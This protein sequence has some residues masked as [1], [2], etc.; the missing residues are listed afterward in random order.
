[1]ST[2]RRTALAILVACLFTAVP[3]IARAGSYTVYGCRTPTGT[4]APVNGWSYSLQVYPAYW[5]NSCPGETFM[6]MAASTP[7]G[8]GRYAE[9]T[10]VA[11]PGT[12]IH[13]YT[14]VRAVRLVSSGGY[15]YQ[16]L[17]NSRGYWSMVEGCNTYTS[18]PSF[19]D[20]KHATSSSNVLSRTAPSG[21][22]QVQLKI[23]CGMS[24]GCP[25]EP[26]GVSASVWMFQ[27]RMTL[28]DDLA[29]QFTGPPSG[30]L[31]SGGVLSGTVP[32]SIGAADQ[33][34]G[35]DFAEV[36]VDGRVLLR[37]VLDNSTGACQ[38][39]F[40]APAPCPLS[41]NGTLNFNT[42]QLPDGTHNLRLAV[43]DAAG[44]VATWGPVA[45][46]TVNN[47]CSPV[48]AAAGMR[49]RAAFAI[50]TR[51]RIRIHGH[52][53]VVKRVRFARK[54]TAN[55]GQH[56]VVLGGLTTT[57][58]TPVPGA[59][60]CIAAQNDLRG[61]RLTP[62]GAVTTNAGGGFLF[63]LAPGPSRTV[64]MIYRVPAGAIFAK[65]HIT[66]HAPVHIHVNRFHFHNGD[67]MSWTGH[68]PGPIP[69]GM[70]ALMQV[71]RGTY[72]QDFQKIAVDRHGRWRGRYRFAFTTGDQRYTF[73]LLVPQQAGY[74]YAAG[75]TPAFHVTVTG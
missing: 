58:G 6:W 34:S 22:T 20:Y 67:V 39:P 71:W 13:N 54:L 40:V 17:Q 70:L 19:G 73:R 56:P 72:W 68:L 51:R 62:A 7:H 38:P 30:P 23:I 10:F 18:C 45:I 46:T 12:T 66:V 48:P 55:Y 41:A 59:R 21:T 44:N 5:S 26:G 24:N 31:V 15:Y 42:A 65:V 2:K 47:P 32:V 50:T 33:G 74:P 63:R 36:Q 4:V 49:L 75:H 60:V 25:S 43:T 37:Q 3:S 28:E 64:Y 16:A 53:R 52:R 27:S 8:Y 29:P 11:P 35:V 69:H 57:S 1:M 61:A 9:E 14:I